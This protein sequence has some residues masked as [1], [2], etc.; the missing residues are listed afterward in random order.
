LPWAPGITPLAVRNCTTRC[1]V[2]PD[3]ASS[4]TPPEQREL[5]RLVSRDSGIW[6]ALKPA[7]RGAKL[8]VPLLQSSK[9]TVSVP[10]SVRRTA[11]GS[12]LLPNRP[13]VGW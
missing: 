8:S 6:P 5:Y 7:T 11:A 2:A 9:R 1:S 10:N 3:F 13:P 12:K 4:E